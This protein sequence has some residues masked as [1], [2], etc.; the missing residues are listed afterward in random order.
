VN[1]LPDDTDVIVLIPP[2]ITT[3]PRHNSAVA[4]SVG[5]ADVAHVDPMPVFNP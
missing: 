3:T 5:V 2:E 1:V 4:D